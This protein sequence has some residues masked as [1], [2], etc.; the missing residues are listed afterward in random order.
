M[1]ACSGSWPLPVTFMKP[2]FTTSMTGA[3]SACSL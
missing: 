2:A 1:T 3:L